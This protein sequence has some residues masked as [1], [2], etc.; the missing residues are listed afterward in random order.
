[1]TAT[2]TLAL[3]ADVNQQEIPGAGFEDN[4][5]GNSDVASTRN[6]LFATYDLTTSVGPASGRFNGL[7]E[8]LPTSLGSLGFSRISDTGTF[9]ATLGTPA[10]PEPTSLTLLGIGAVGIIGYGWRRRKRAAV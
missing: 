10:A 8:V 9:T 3:Q 1:L 6:S 2:V 5:P 7:G 4:G